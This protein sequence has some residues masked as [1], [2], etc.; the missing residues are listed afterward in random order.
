MV[1]FIPTC[2]LISLRRGGQRD[3]SP[4]GGPPSRLSE[5]GYV[6][7]DDPALVGVG[8]GV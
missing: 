7:Q 2:L 3:V 6:E 4:R 5:H 1:N 8:Y